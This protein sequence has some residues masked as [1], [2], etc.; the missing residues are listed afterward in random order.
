MSHLRANSTKEIQKVYAVSAGALRSEQNIRAKYTYH[1][2]EGINGY[3]L[4]SGCKIPLYR[5]D[6]TSP[7]QP[8]QDTSKTVQVIING[9]WRQTHPGV[10]AAGHQFKSTSPTRFGD[11]FI[12]T[13]PEPSN[14]TGM[15]YRT[16][17]VTSTGKDEIRERMGSSIPQ[18]LGKEEVQEALVDGAMQKFDERLDHEVAAI[19]NG[20][21]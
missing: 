21:R 1:P 16:G 10:A 20:W 6:G 8:T 2:G 13:M 7:L 11:A 9:H 17:G 18:M 19:L 15:F 12:A 5:H 14:H 3:V 4:F